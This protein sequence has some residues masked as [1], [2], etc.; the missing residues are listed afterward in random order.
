[1]IDSLYPISPAVNAAEITTISA[2]YRKQVVKVM[3]SILLFIVSYI[4]VLVGSV[5]FVALCLFLAGLFLSFV[6]NWIGFLLLL[7]AG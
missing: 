6:R 1:M 7:G 3:L 4:A 5:A 2:V